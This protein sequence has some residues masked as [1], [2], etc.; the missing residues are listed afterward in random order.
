MPNT[1]A[2]RQAFLAVRFAAR[3]P[4]LGSMAPVTLRTSNAPG[5]W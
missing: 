5:G 3:G 4:G 1:V 2:E